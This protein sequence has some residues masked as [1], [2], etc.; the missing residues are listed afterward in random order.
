MDLLYAAFADCHAIIIASPLPD[1]LG[2]MLLG[3]S[4]LT[5]RQIAILTY[6]FNTAGILVIVVPISLFL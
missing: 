2:L 6:I 4:K 1:E 3:A 5:Y